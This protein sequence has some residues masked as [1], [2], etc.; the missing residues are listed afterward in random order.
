MKNA[1]IFKLGAFDAPHSNE[2]NK[3]GKFISA[4]FFFFIFIHSKKILVIEF[5]VFFNRNVLKHSL[6]TYL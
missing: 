3:I 2:N 6:S 5:N 4:F 1:T